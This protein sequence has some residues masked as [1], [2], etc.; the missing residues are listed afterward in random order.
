MIPIL[1]DKTEILFT[2]NGLGRLREATRCRVTEERNGIYELE[3]DYP[4]TGAMYDSI[5]EGRII[6]A[7]HDEQGDPQ[8]F[9]IYKRS[10]PIAGI[11]TFYAH[12]ISYRL[13]E[14]TVK[15]F[16][17]SSC[18]SALQMIKT[19]SVLTNP[20]TFWTDKSVSANYAVEV[21]KNAK[22]LL[23]GE[24][25]SILDI[26]GTGEYEFDKFAVKLHLHRG[27]DT[28]ISIRYGKNLSDFTN[29]YDAAGVYTAVVPFW[30]G[31]YTAEAEESGSDEDVTETAAAAESQ[32]VLV[33][34][35]EWY[36]ASGNAAPSGRQILIPLDMSS[37]FQSMPSVAELR[38]AAT[39]KLATAK[40]WIPSQTI[41]VNFVQ[42]WQTEEYKDYAPLQRLRLCDTCGIF[43]PM[44]NMSLRAKV[45]KTVY[46]TLLDRYDEMELGDKP[47]T[48]E[49]VL[50]KQYDSKVAGV[51]QGFQSID[52]DL[53]TL[54]ANASADASAKADAAQAAA[55][56]TASADATSKANTAL[57]QAKNY[58]NSEIESLRSTLETQI[59]AK[60]ET[61]AQSSDPAANWTTASLRAEHNGDLWLYTGTRSITVNSVTIK[62][63]GVYQYNSSTGIWAAYSSTSSNLFDIVDGKTTIFYGST[64][65]TYSG[66]ET[67]DY[68][69]NP[70]TGSTYRWTGSAW[71]KVTDYRTYTDAQITSA[72]S[73]IQ[74][75]YEQ[76]IEDAT[77]LIRGGTGGYVVTTVNA[78]G[79]PIE[80]LI[81]DNLDLNQAVNVWRWNQGGLAH[82][83]TGYNGTYSDVAITADGKI[84]ASAILTG[85]LT[86][87][88][89][90]SGVIQSGTGES[91][92][93]LD[94]GLLVIS[95][96]GPHAPGTTRA[97][98][99]DFNVYIAGD[100]QA[101]SGIGMIIAAEG[102][103]YEKDYGSGV[104]DYYKLDEAIYIVAAQGLTANNGETKDGY[105]DYCRTKSKIMATG[106]LLIASGGGELKR[107]TSIEASRGIFGA[108]TAWDSYGMS[109]TMSA[110]TQKLLCTNTT[111]N[112]LFQYLTIEPSQQGGYGTGLF[113]GYL[114]CS[115]GKNRLMETNNYGERLLYCYEMPSAMFGDIGQ[116][117]IDEEGICVVDI[118]DIFGE[119]ISNAV[120][121]NVFLQKEGKGDCWIADKQGGY[122]VV[123]GTPNLKFSWELK[124][125][126][127]DI[128]YDYME[129]YGQ[130]K[131]AIKGND[132]AYS[133]LSHI[134]ND[135]IRYIEEQE[136]ILS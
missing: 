56:A 49:S 35:P 31:S 6:Y 91:Y 103:D 28:N 43:V 112:G 95:K 85:I 50:E 84:N 114:T 109:L 104:I 51:I 77:E 115:G 40:G 8:P 44:Y 93:D 67:G 108:A 86:A 10:E 39:S 21:P 113:K 118:N 102:N 20:F 24:Q 111:S 9:D 79:Q 106:D 52:V 66:K 3:L 129:E 57:T 63:Q 75:E 88:L 130:R 27:Q 89:I 2:S 81:T 45:V 34:L 13:G 41:R 12:H 110:K 117:Q 19:Q 121:Y 68:L 73:T 116:G 33:V 46:N 96:E 25:G 80:L 120:E 90:K 134:E 105:R 11:V 54:Q 126:Q 97:T 78:N 48:F 14:H 70:S 53:A 61:W 38:S 87:N 125:R 136:G 83:S 23:A 1:F 135:Y 107:W 4:V 5:Q 76:A 22:G 60:I 7:T 99:G 101:S 82:S 92:W 42:L 74:E 94:N 71:S 64:S 100:T 119:T 32:E 133:T 132:D 124:A 26:F 15:P 131:D 69:V 17:A 30:K 122:F 98:I 16:T 47:E 72:K 36:I 123:E 37:D 55:E 59:D 62:P 29:D 18:A 65:G 127:K 58:I 128:E